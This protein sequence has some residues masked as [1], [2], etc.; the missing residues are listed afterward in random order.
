MKTTM[1][2]LIAIA[3]TTATLSANAASEIRLQGAAFDEI[4]AGTGVAMVLV[5]DTKTQVEVMGSADNIAY[6][7]TRIEG[8]TLEIYAQIPAQKQGDK[9]EA[10]VYVHYVQPITDIECHSSAEVTNKGY[11]LRCRE[12][13]LEASSAG[14][15]ALDVACEKIDAE[16]SSAG[17]V[18]LTGEAGRA[19]VEASAGGTVDM[20]SVHLSTA[21]AEA[22]TGGAVY[23]HTDY[24]S[25]E[26]TLGGEVHYKGSP[27]ISKKEI[28]MG[29]E[30]RSYK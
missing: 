9:Y 21:D 17:S 2:L 28:T 27:V 8:H 23:I 19:D 12:L 4:E 5:P 7:V 11:T 16:A 14:R 25:V 13:Q 30:I 3:M 29:G 24:L 18:V 22:S 20:K 6:T 26:A 1:K 10:T 15:I